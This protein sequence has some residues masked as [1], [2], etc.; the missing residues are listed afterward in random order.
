MRKLLLMFTWLFC[1][2]AFV[3]AQT[4]QITGTVYSSEDGGTLPGVTI[5]VKGTTLG[6]I[7]DAD[8]KYS[9]QVPDDAAVLSFSFVGM[10]TMDVEIGSKTTINVTLEPS[11]VSIDEVVVTALGIK[12]KEKALGYAAT[13]VNSDEI[14]KSQTNDVMSALS[15]KIAG[16][17]I[18]TSSSSPGASNAV[19]IRGMS[20]LGGANQPL[21]V[22]DGVPIIN[23]TV[24]STSLNGGYDFGAGNQMI[25]PYDVESVTVLKGSAASALYGSRAK[26]G[27]IV[28]TTK[29]GKKD[30]DIKVEINGTVQMSDILRLPEYQNEFGM[31]WDG[32]HTLI[33]NGSWGPKFDGS[34]RLWGT[35]YNNSQKLKPFVAQP[36]NLYD[37]F[38][39]GMKYSSNISVSGGNGNTTYYA[40]LSQVDD[41]GIIP[42]DHDRLK[43]YTAK[44]R[45]THEYKNFKIS[46]NVNISKQNNAFVP[47]GQGFTIMNNLSQI[48]RDISIVS[49]RDYKTDAFNSLDYYFTPYG[50]INP[51]YALDNLYTTYS[52]QKVFGGIEMEYK[53]TNELSVRNRLGYDATDYEQKIASPRL[54]TTPGTPNF[55]EVSDPGGVLKSM[56]RRN[57]INNDFFINYMKEVG[58][59]DFTLILGTS[60][61]SRTYSDVSA[62][63]ANLS[64]PDFYDLSNTAETPTVGEYYSN[65]RVFGAFFNAEIAYKDLLFLTLTGRRDYSSTL[66]KEN[67]YYDYPAAQVSF[68]FSDLLSDDLQRVISLGKVRASWGQTGADAGPYLLDPYFVAASVGNP[69]GNINFPLSQVNAY[70]VGNRLANITLQPE[71]RTE[72]EFGLQ[73]NFFTGRVGFDLTYYNGVSNKQIYN[74]EMAPSTGYTSQTT[75]LGEITNKGIELQVDLVPIKT[76]NF[77]WNLSYNYYKNDEKLVSLPDELG[78]KVN[79][80]GLSTVGFV[81]IVGEPLGLFELTVPQKTADG[82]IVVDSDGLPVAAAEKAIVPKAAYDYSMGMTNTFTYKDVSLSF[83]IDYRQGG[84]IYSRTK[85]I[86]MFTGNLKETIYNDRN[87]FVVPNSVNEIADADGVMDADGSEEFDYVENT[88]PVNNSTIVSFFMDGREEL[89]R[90]FLLPRTFVKLKNVSLS[91]SLPKKLL[92]STP[93]SGVSVSVYGNNLWLWTPTENY[94]ID[95]QVTTFGNDINSR[96]GEFSANPPTRSWGANVKITF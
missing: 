82:R 74:L 24:A 65:Y 72:Y 80:G 26:N 77:R 91:Y 68:V 59:F 47:T 64:I 83:D 94:L 31:G 4:K 85:D 43:R 79:L 45:G 33:E 70:E 92:A 86:N 34:M 38:D 62:S 96:Y 95:P 27:V 16:V 49:L 19:I 63:I 84:L 17:D 20:S 61:L 73:M 67:N 18:S 58:D 78:N 81:A 69:F 57:E 23:N 13:S 8:G 6:T 11:Q 14:V 52:S 75:N 50:V 56:T 28:I 90:A 10:E 9:I 55:E 15:G 44:F 29:S 54:V 1:V 37:F 42:E 53:I 48:P 60:L 35:I 32:H 5:Q 25:N 71:I 46:T 93:L 7:S 21:Y 39:Y 40:S 51:Y 2:M 30:Q 3:N 76:R 87:P 36:N 22:I 66:P 88:V 12:R 89:D 41:N